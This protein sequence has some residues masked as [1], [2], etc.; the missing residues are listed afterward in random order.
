[1]LLLSIILASTLSSILGL[2]GGF[3]LLWQQAWVKKVSSYFLSFAV[4]TLLAVT[5]FDLIPEV[6]AQKEAKSVMPAILL[7]MI[8]FF[9]LERF[10][11]WYHC[12]EENCEVHALPTLVLIGDAIHNAID[13]VAIAATFLINP[14]LG[15]LT[16]LAVFAHEIPQEI[17]DFSILIHAGLSRAKVAWLNIIFSLTS[18]LAAIIGYYTISRQFIWLATAV[19]AGNLLYLACADLIPEIHHEFKFGK[20]LGQII[21][22]LLGV[23]LMWYLGQILPHA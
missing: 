19:A 21:I 23:W 12:H 15:W 13:G 5:F 7:G 4:G 22:M 17:G 1:M 9:I 18:P 3:F 14:A 6:L 8:F 2:A 16:T 10:L 11:I 20:V